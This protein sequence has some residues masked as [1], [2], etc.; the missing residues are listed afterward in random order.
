MLSVEEVRVN[1]RLRISQ[2][3]AALD[4]MHKDVAARKSESRKRAVDAYNRKV[5]VRPINFD[6]GY[7]VLRSVLDRERIKKPALR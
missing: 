7:Y 4:N 6:E 1:Q 3:Q 5:G 2:I